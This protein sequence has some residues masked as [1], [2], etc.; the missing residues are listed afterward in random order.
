MIISFFS[1]ICEMSIKMTY[2]AWTTWGI[3][4]VCFFFYFSSHLHTFT[5]FWCISIFK[6]NP[7]H[8]V[9]HHVQH[10][11]KRATSMDSWY[12]AQFHHQ[13]IYICRTSLFYIRSARD[14]LLKYEIIGIFL[15]AVYMSKNCVRCHNSNISSTIITLL[16]PL[17]HFPVSSCI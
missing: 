15:K 5:L 14:S 1:N 8:I 11:T 9:E 2:D 13:I 6:E 7:H 12:Y 10:L 3:F 17:R 4:C 16:L